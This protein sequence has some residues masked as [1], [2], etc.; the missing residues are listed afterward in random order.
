MMLAHAYAHGMT[1]DVSAKERRIGPG[2]ALR[3]RRIARVTLPATSGTAGALFHGLVGLHPR[4][5]ISLIRLFA[6]F[7]FSRQ[8]GRD[9]RSHLFPSIILF[10]FSY[11]PHLSPPSSLTSLDFIRAANDSYLAAVSTAGSFILRRIS[12]R[13]AVRFPCLG[14][15][16]GVS[17]DEMQIL[18]KREKDVGRRNVKLT[19]RH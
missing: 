15:V 16:T 9:G 5:L 18:P 10:A 14:N 7:S 2:I 4:G 19:R 8:R 6:L 1:D 13:D 11:F 17:A 3:F 12:A